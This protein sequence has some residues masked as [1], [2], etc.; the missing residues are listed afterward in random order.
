[1]LMMNTLIL[2]AIHK[3]A[4]EINKFSDTSNNTNDNCNNT[5]NIRTCKTRSIMLKR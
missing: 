3:R 5:N 1:M 4:F 2:S